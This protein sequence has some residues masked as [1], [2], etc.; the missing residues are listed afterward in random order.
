MRS[1]V[2]IVGVDIPGNKRLV[3][4][5]TYIFGIGKARSKEIIATLRLNEDMKAGELDA[6]QIADLNRLL[7]SR[8]S[9]EGALRRE[10]KE[11]IDRLIRIGCYRGIRHKIGLP[12]RGQSTKRNA[13]TRKGKRRTVANKKI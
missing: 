10:I 13:R 8:Y 6:T 1:S 2:K 11:Y 7:Q 12:V 5:L 3:I 9:L 4:A